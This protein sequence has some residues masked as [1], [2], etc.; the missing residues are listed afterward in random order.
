MTLHYTDGSSAGFAPV[1]NKTAP[2][3]WQEYFLITTAG[4]TVSH[5]TSYYY[6]S[7]PVYYRWDSYIIPY[8]TENINKQGV[9]SAGDL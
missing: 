4:K 9:V 5:M 1:G 6:T 7:I 8:V 2:K 3:G